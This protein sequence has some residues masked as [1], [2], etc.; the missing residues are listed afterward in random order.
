MYNS[1]SLS[2]KQYMY[3]GLLHL[4][5]FLRWITLILLAVAFVRSLKG[6]MKKS[7]YSSLD[8]KISLFSVITSHIQ[9]IIGVLLYFISPIVRYGLTD[10][11]AAMKDP[12]LRF[13]TIEHISV[14]ILSI[15][16]ITLGHLLSKRTTNSTDKYKKITIFF[17]LGL[18]L[19][20]MR[21]PFCSY[22]KGGIFTTKLHSEN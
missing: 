3:T 9:L 1:V 17:G 12:A 8:N 2:E 4:H 6:W 21:I 10:F 5:S 18:L 15:I 7:N 22:P 14:M 13:W 16:L 19:I 20:L 11:V